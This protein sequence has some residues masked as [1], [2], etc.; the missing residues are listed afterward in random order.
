MSYYDL[1]ARFVPI[2]AW[3]GE[4]TRSRRASPF[5][6]TWGNTLSLLR[7]ELRHLGAKNILVQVDMGPSQIRL[8]GYPRADARAR[9]PGVILTFESKFGPLS[10]PC[11]TFT[12]WEANI[13]AIAMSLEN[14]RAVDRYGVTKRGEQYTGWKKLGSGAVRVAMTTDQAAEFIA[15]LTVWRPDALLHDPE[16]YRMAYRQAATKLHPDVGGTTEEFQR[17]QEAKRV[18]DKHHGATQ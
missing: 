11:D 8:D 3:P 4:R 16:S 13:R 6:A 7:A 18:L 12:S 15:H 10:Y 14:L 17:L 5:R 1:N 9:G 2:E